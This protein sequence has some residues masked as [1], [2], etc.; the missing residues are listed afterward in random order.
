MMSP[1]PDR[2]DTV[3]DLAPIFSASQR[4]SEHPCS[5]QSPSQPRCVFPSQGWRHVIVG[6]GQQGLEGSC[7][8]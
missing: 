5:R 6:M 4:I 1:S 8:A 7:H 3:A 2:P